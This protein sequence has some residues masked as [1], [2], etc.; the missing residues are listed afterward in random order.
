MLQNIDKFNK[1]NSFK[2]Y[3]LVKNILQRER[4]SINKKAK[5]HI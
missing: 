2:E 3:E 4:E 1:I 5:V